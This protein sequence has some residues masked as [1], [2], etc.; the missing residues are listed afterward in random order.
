MKWKLQSGIKC[1]RGNNMYNEADTC[2]K[3]VLPK[4]YSSGWTDDQINEQKTF[5]DG[6]IVVAGD[7]CTRR[8]QKRADYLLR[9]R[10]NLMIAVVEAK[11][12]YK[13]SA[14][15]IQQAKEYAEILNLKFAYSTNGHRII[16][17]DFIT[18]IEKEMDEFPPISSPQIDT[19]MKRI[20]TLFDPKKNSVRPVEIRKE[21]NRGM[22][23]WL[24]LRR[25]DAGLRKA[26]EA[27]REIQENDLPRM[28]VQ[29]EKIFNYELQEAMEVGFMAQTAEMVAQAA[30]LRTESRG[31]HLRS[32]YPNDDPSWLKH[33]VVEK[34]GR[35]L[36]CTTAPVIRW[37]E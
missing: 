23:T 7:R 17:H 25:D 30:L 5:T 10:S 32:D 29:N 4:L 37:T 9:F 1:K 6:R 31:H 35:E 22:E 2:R 21:I 8:S 11:A 28:Q 20:S 34:R 19:A 24:G 14:D 13:G 3:Y 16:E 18:G 36:I 27:F 26:I 12:S 15:G 33:T